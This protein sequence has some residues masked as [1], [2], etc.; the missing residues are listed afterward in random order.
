M[1]DITYIKHLMM[2]FLFRHFV[3]NYKPYEKVKFR[4]YN[5]KILKEVFFYNFW[6]LKLFCVK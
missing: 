2:S 4:N 5:F 1:L 3:L 6:K